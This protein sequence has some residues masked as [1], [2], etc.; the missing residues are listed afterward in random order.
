MK[1]TIIIAAV[2]L[3]SLSACNKQL[4][5]LRPHNVIN[6]DAQFSTPEGFSQ[7]ALGLYPMI[8]S[9]VAME[10]S[11]FG[12]GDVTM[13]LS[14]TH[15]NNIHSLDLGPNRYSDAFDYTNSPDKDHSWT[16]YLWRGSY[17][18]ILHANKLLDNVTKEEQRP[19]VLQ[20]KAE[21]LFVRAFVYFNLVRFYAKPYYQDAA[22]S[23]GVMLITTAANGTG[24]KPARASVKAVYEQI[25]SDLETAIPLFNQEKSNSFAGKMSAAALL[26]RVYLYMG[27]TFQQPDA[28]FNQQAVSYA[29]QVINSNKY[30]LLTGNDYRAYYNSSNAANKEDIFAGNT[31]YGSTSISQQ[32]AY[33]P[34]INYTGGYYRPSPDL[35]TRI[36]TTDL[37]T[38]HYKVNVT[39]GFPNDSIATAKYMYL[40]TAIYSK[41][42]FRYIRLAEVYLNRAEANAKLGKKDL[43]LADLNI[44]R[45]RAGL[46]SV[47]LSGQALLDEILLQRRLELAFEGHIG[48][49]FFRNGLPMVRN[50]AS[51]SSGAMTIAATSPKIL[52]RIPQEEIILNPNL[53]QNEQ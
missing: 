24:Y 45:N 9:G 1:R 23:P 44:I 48:F 6:E 25:V 14:E 30:T 34:Q 40:Y 49:D 29:D 18:T 28:T 26:S 37:R 19:A 47:D 7:A 13:F 12:Y 53:T 3:I 36:S 33:P 32:Y 46:V 41:S 4:D 52:L 31:D 43:A 2:S 17:F 39:P 16:Y 11:S 8:T 27:G 42:P 20:A 5:E 21:A 15:G 50:Y 35:L 10:N 38:S 51:A 22:G